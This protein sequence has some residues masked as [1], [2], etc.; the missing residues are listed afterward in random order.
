MS[1]IYGLRNIE[2]VIRGLII[3]LFKAKFCWIKSKLV[4]LNEHNYSNEYDFENVEG[5]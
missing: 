5:L 2:I 4:S 3:A 1:E